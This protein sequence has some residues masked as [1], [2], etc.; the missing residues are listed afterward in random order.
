MATP[1]FT[2]HT[3]DQE[4]L[5]AHSAHKLD[6]PS[7]ITKFHLF[8]HASQGPYRKRRREERARHGI[9]LGYLQEPAY[10][11]EAPGIDAT[12]MDGRNFTSPPLPALTFIPARVLEESNWLRD[13]TI[14]ITLEA[15][16]E[17]FDGVFT[18]FLFL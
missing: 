1:L 13:T 2:H 3:D 15:R 18:S 16:L 12:G 7:N 8:R 10:D 5:Y 14:G 9:G 11:Y 17:E 4:H 6:D